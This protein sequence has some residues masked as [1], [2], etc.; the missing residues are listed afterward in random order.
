MIG[1]LFKLAFLLTAL[2]IFAVVLAAGVL[3]CNLFVLN[4]GKGRLFSNPAAIPARDVGLVLGTSEKL[5]NG[6]DNP[7][8]INRIA[9]AAELFHQRKV[10]HLIVSGD[11]RWHGYNEP[12]DMRDALVRRGVPARA[13]TLDLAGVRTLDSIV[14]AQKIFGLKKCTIISQRDHDQ[15]AL[16]LADHFGLDAIAFCAQDVPFRL[17]VQPH[18]REWFARVKVILDLYVLHTQ[19]RQLGPREPITLR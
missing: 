3:A 12:A 5:L 15:R 17:A 16:L 18:I 8:F 13:I 7:Y 11:N 6:R 2:A 4:C 9:A 19:P 1:R 14:R 10:R